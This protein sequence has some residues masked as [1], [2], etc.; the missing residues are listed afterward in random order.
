[1]NSF[2]ILKIYTIYLREYFEFNEK[3]RKT[4]YFIRYN[5]RNN[6]NNYINAQNMLTN[7]N[8]RFDSK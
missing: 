5:Y 4:L 8:D 2:I 7:W 3:L 1:M 6:E